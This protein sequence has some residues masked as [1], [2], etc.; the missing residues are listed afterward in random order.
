MNIPSQNS[1]AQVLNAFACAKTPLC[2]IDD[3]L[4]F[5]AF[6]SALTL[7]HVFQRDF[8]V[9]LRLTYLSTIPDYFRSTLSTYADTSSIE[10]ETSPE[11][12][13]FSKH[14]LVVY[15][16]SAEKL[17]P[18]NFA[19]FEIP[20]NMTVVNI[21]HHVGSNSFFGTL[22]VV[23]D[24]PSTC[25][26]LYEIFSEARLTIDQTMARLL[27]LGIL[28]DTQVFSIMGIKGSDLSTVSRLLDISGSEF[29]DVV[30]DLTWN[31]SR[32]FFELKK[33]VYKNAV[34]DYEQ[35]VAY[36]FV[37]LSEIAEHGIDPQFTPNVSP[38]DELKLLDGIDL[39]F[40]LK[41]KNQENGVFSINFRSHAKTC[42]VSQIAQSFEGGGHSMAAGGIMRGVGSVQEAIENVLGA[43]YLYRKNN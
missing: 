25:S 36:S 18:A 26:L 4:D 11:G 27:I 17:K 1:P 33:I 23:R 21:D 40:L 43:I 8:G 19:S 12:I 13:D 38:A 42:N 6:C 9:V 7:R 28:D 3:R 5:D 22:N 37:L 14:D 29:F 2:M 41:E 10:T 24:T 32:D 20:E 31:E 34:V 35:K 39:A 16:D 30:R 15:L